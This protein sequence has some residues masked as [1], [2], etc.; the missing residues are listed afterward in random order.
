MIKDSRLML[1]SSGFTCRIKLS[2]KKTHFRSCQFRD[3]GSN[4]RFKGLGHRKHGSL[5][6]VLF[7]CS[8]LD[9]EDVEL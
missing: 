4:L 7:S 1:L 9:E 3:S 5:K 8:K 6:Q 2:N